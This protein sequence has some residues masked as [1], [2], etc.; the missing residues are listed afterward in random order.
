MSAETLIA[1]AR[2]YASNLVS[3]ASHAMSDAAR[4]VERIGYISPNPTAVTIPSAPVENLGL[5]APVLS[6]VDMA[7]VTPPAPPVTFQDI[8]V[9]DTSGL[10]VLSATP[11][12]ITLPTAPS[13]LAGFN[14]AAPTISTNIAFPEPPSALMAPL[15]DA[16]VLPTR[17]E[18]DKPQTM[19]PSFSVSAPTGMPDAPTALA[20]SFDA[21]YR[22]AAPSTITMLNGFVDAQLTKFNP[23]YAEQMGKI[24]DQLATY[25]AGGTGLNPAA[26][27]A[28][29]ERARGKNDAEARRVRDAAF[30][31]AAARGFTLP[32]GAL[33]SALQQA[34]QAAAD[35]NA[36]AAREI[37]VMQAEMEQKNLQFA[38][39]TSADL[40]KTMLSAALSYHQ[41]LISINGQALDYAKTVMGAMIEVYNAAVKAYGVR[42]D[43]YRAEASVYEIKLKAAM[44]GIELYQAEIQALTALTNVD[45]TKV[46]VYRA[47]IEVLTSLSNVYRSQIEAV[48]GRTSLEKLKLEVFQAKVQTYATQVQGKNAEWQGFTA[49]IEGQTA[50]AK[51]YGIEVEAYGAK[52]NGYKAGIEAKSA[53]VQAAALTNK[54]RADQY[55]ASIQGYSAVVQ[56]NGVVAQTKLENQRQGIIAFQAQSQAVVAN[57]QVKLT[58][59]QISSGIAIKNAEMNMTAQIQQAETRR[60]YSKSIADLGTANAQIY[61]GAANAA[62]SGM[63]S[64]AATILTES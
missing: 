27:T 25:L 32:P 21:A 38:V 4:A 64:F 5:V 59:Y 51:I 12:A 56:A 44:A 43:T 20:D 40:R 15:F 16:P 26:E 36:T 55:T 49:A 62:M 13:Q 2:S 3:D 37:V 29:Y 11:P 19:I 52:V 24:E 34:R 35:N 46:D 17:V 42:L 31:D 45:R 50:R 18:P 54:A 57:A 22:N 63:N 14:E 48:V 23:R 61:T 28:I 30:K 39:T 9:V 58:Y 60:A 1:D 41:N 10:P 47:R 8:P 33:S 6:P 7:Q 53:A